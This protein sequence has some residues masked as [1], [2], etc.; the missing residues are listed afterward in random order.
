[1]QL[2]H[3]IC[4]ASLAVAA[5]T[6]GRLGDAQ[7][8]K[9][10]PTPSPNHLS[11]TGAEG[12]LEA[13][14]YRAPEVEKRQRKRPGRSHKS[15]GSGVATCMSIQCTDGIAKRSN[16]AVE[17]REPKRSNNAVEKRRLKRPGGGYKSIGSGVA[18]CM[19]STGCGDGL[20][21]RSNNAVEKREPKRSDNA[22]E[23]REPK[24]PGG[25][26][27]SIGS[28]VATCMG[29]RCGDFAKRSD[30]AVER[31]FVSVDKIGGGIAPAYNPRVR[32]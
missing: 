9:R 15:I 14:A 13:R 28:G 25:G 26:Y 30:D 11:V 20:A 17:K 10:E 6:H 22:V 32:T 4:L 29:S 18:T 21:K 24:R 7:V 12:A 31:R 3:A 19:G 8:E 16:D 5:P 23:K 2:W 1:M 27:K